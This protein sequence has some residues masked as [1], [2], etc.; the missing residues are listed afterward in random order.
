MSLRLAHNE[1]L[2]SQGIASPLIGGWRI[3]RGD[4]LGRHVC[5]PRQVRNLPRATL[6]A[7]RLQVVT[8]I[9]S[10]GTKGR[11]HAGN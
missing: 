6:K 3:I 4:A 9:L 7:L 1:A 8:W 10:D 11:I 5:A 2:R